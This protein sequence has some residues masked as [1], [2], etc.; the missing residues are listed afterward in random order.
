M[1][2]KDAEAT[3]WVH[4]EGIAIH[5]AGHDWGEWT[6][7]VPATEKEMGAERRTCKNNPFHFQFRVIPQKGHMHGLVHFDAKAPTCEEGGNIEYWK[8]LEGEYPCGLCYKDAGGEEWV[9]EDDIPVPALGHD[10]GEWVVVTPATDTAEGLKQRTCTRCGE[11][12][13]QVIPKRETAKVTVTFEANGGKGAMDVL[14]AA[15]GSKVKLPA[16]AFKRAGY[17]FKG[18][19][20]EKNGKGAAYKNKAAVS[21]SGNLTLYAQWKKKVSGTLATKMKAKGPSSL[22]LSWSKVKGAEGYDI[23]F[24]RC[25][26]DGMK[27]VPLKVK[28]FK[29][30]NV[31]TWTKGKLKEH[32]A[33]KACVKAY[34]VENGKKRYV[35]KSLQAHAYTSGGTM[36][37]TN[38]KSI[39]LKKSQVKIKAGKT[40]RVK[41]TI[42]K[43]HKDKELMRGH[44]PRLRF[45]TSNKKIATVS[46]GGVIKARGKGTCFILVYAH[47]GISKKVRV[48]V[49]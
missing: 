1:Y 31:F 38:A 18:W 13:T 36:R 46:K 39:K 12:E 11:V 3:Q 44:V 49:R 10:W 4:E 15:V 8:C 20:T 30:N 9:H 45:K 29:G 7:I 34:V 41:A 23:F 47:D 6:V 42:A 24:S 27:L 35:R 33:Y 25:N 17:T 2:F 14:R 19:N 21:L 26:H 43:L 5:A 32:T 37:F 28:S 48:T 16:N 22:V 40:S